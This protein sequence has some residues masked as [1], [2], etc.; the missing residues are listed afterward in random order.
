MTSTELDGRALRDAFGHFPSGVVA[1]CAE[2]ERE[3]IGMAASTFVSVSLDPPLVAVC[4]Q[5]TSTTW[6]KLRAA[7]GLGLSVL[8][9]EHGAVARTLAAKTGDRFDGVATQSGPGGALLVHGAALWLAATIAEE[10]PAGDH[11]VALLAIDWLEVPADV[12]P[13]V[14]HRSRFHRLERAGG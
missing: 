7:G 11:L 8:G 14:F 5:T 2:T 3:R 6:P 1:I 9:E 10:V 12:A 4:I 13:I